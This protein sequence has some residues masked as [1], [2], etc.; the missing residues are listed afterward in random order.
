MSKFLKIFKNLDFRDASWFVHVYSVCEG[1]LG[2]SY[3]LY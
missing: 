1:T 2:R 3:S